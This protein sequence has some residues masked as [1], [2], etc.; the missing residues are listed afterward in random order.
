MTLL[1]ADIPLFMRPMLRLPYKTT[2]MQL[3]NCKMQLVREV[4]YNRQKKYRLQ[5]KTR[6][7]VN[8]ELLVAK[9]Y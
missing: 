7:Y 4:D 9:S 8:A 5:Q 3:T 2:D 6:G 1:F